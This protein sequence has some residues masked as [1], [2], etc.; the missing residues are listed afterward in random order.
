VS[1]AIVSYQDT[2]IKE[3]KRLD[4]YVVGKRNLS[5][6]GRASG[7]FVI[8]LTNSS[9]TLEAYVYPAEILYFPA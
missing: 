3:M 5:G 2:K 7:E 9:K 6:P 1:T 4:W 8:K